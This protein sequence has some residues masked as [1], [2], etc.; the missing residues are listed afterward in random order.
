[1]ADYDNPRPISQPIGSTQGVVAKDNLITYDLVVNAPSGTPIANRKG[2]PLTPLVDVIDGAASI[3]QDGINEAI[4]RAAMEYIGVWTDGATEF[5]GYNQYAIYNGVAYGTR[6][7]ATLPVTVG[8]QPDNAIF[9]AL[10]FKC[11]I[12][13]ADV[14]IPFGNNIVKTLAGPLLNTRATT[15]GNINKSGVSETLIAD[16]IG[17]TKNGVSV[18]GSYTNS[19]LWSEDPE[20]SPWVVPLDG[21]GVKPLLISTNN[22]SSEIGLDN[23]RLIDDISVTDRQYIRQVVDKG[24]SFSSVSVSFEVKKD[25]RDTC[26]FRIAAAGGDAVFQTADFS[27]STGQIL[28]SPLAG[29]NY[30][31]DELYDGWFR[32]NAVITSTGADNNTLDLRVFPASALIASETGS[33]FVS[34]CS[35]VFDAGSKVPYVKT[36]A[37][38]KVSDAD[39]VTFQ[40]LNNLP[41]SGES[42]TIRARCS[43]PDDGASRYVWSASSSV[44]GTA[45]FLR[46]YRTG[47]VQFYFNQ[48][49][50]TSRSANVSGLDTEVH[51]FHCVYDNVLG[52]KLFIDGVLVAQNSTNPE[53]GPVFDY[54]DQFSVGSSSGVESLNSEVSNFK[55]WHKA[56]NDVQVAQDC[57]ANK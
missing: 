31:V 52:L 25:S 48:A 22:P 28:S 11:E 57:Q 34:K 7:T 37:V 39:V 8:A 4:A 29:I 50:G 6:T 30:F 15:R 51:D 36:E 32:I 9:S 18:Y 41:R 44:G 19:L 55:I 26:G 46:R 13:E 47:A 17:V 49:D 3:I 42:L 53:S 10:T 33:S 43:I 45:I 20:V 2:E 14:C 40:Q 21:E 56:L 38:A 1:M 35:V 12:P 23:A 27:F 24:S 5:T 54:T 16:E